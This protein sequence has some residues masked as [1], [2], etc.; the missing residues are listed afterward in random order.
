MDEALD[1][2]LCDVLERIEAG[3][4]VSTQWLRSRYPSSWRDLRGALALD[5]DLAP[6][7]VPVER[8]A[9]IRLGDWIGSGAMGV[10]F[11]GTP[12]D[13]SDA[14]RMPSRV[15]V[16]LLHP[17]FAAGPEF[18][19]R[20]AREIEIGRGVVHANLVRTLASGIEESGGR[21][22][23]YLVMEY[24]EGQTLRALLDE[25]GR[26]PETLCRRI[27]REIAEALAALHAAGAVHRDVK[28]EN[29]VVARSAAPGHGGVA[30]RS[31]ALPSPSPDARAGHVVVGA[32]EFVKLMDY[33]VAFVAEESRRSVEAP[34]FVGTVLYAA[35]EQFSR[36]GARIDGRTDLYALGVV[37]HE[38]ATG[39]H[40]FAAKDARTSLELRMEGPPA[41]SRDFP[42]VSPFFEAAIAR[43]MDPDADG[44]FASAREFADTLAEGE[45]SA[46]WRR[47]SVERGAARQGLRRVVRV[48]REASVAGREPEL[49]ALRGLFAQ[50]RG[51]SGASALLVGEAGVGK[52][53]L[54]DELAVRLAADGEDFH[55]LYGSYSPDAV[56]AGGGAFSAALCGHFGDAALEDALTPRL[57]AL[58][59]LVPAFAAMLRGSAARDAS[60]LSREAVPTLFLETLRSL[61]REK[62]T[63]LV[64][65]DLHFAGGDGLDLLRD[66]VRAI[67]GD[68]VLLVA[69]SRPEA[70]PSRLDELTTS[71]R[72]QRIDLARLGDD[73]VE[74]IVADALGGGVASAEIASE[75]A[76][77]CDGNPL[78]ALGVLQGLR[79]DGAVT[80]ELSGAWRFDR[81]RAG[82]G[83]PVGIREIVRGRLASLDAADRELLDV[84]AC[85][86]FEFD[87]T[88]VGEAI[89]AGPLAV[90]R[91]LAR[92]EMSTRL[93]RSSG[94]LFRFD[95]HLAQETIYAD[96]DTASRAR[97]HGS[98]A[99]AIERRGAESSADSAGDRAVALC[100]HWL[101]AG[102]AE[103]AGPLVI[104]AIDRLVERQEHGAAIALADEALAAGGALDV[105]G[106]IAV[107]LTKVMRLVF[108]GRAQHATAPADEAVALA[109]RQDDAALGAE[110][111]FVRAQVAKALNQHDDALRL[112]AEARES[113]PAEAGS[114]RARIELRLANT[115]CDVNREGEM[116]PHAQAALDWARRNGDTKTE[117]MACLALHIVAKEIGSGGSPSGWL[118]ACIDAAR[119]G[120][121]RS[122]ANQGLTYVARGLLRNGAFAEA[123]RVL[124]TCS[125]EARATGDRRVA[126]AVD[127]LIAQA[128]INLGN[129][130][131][132]R[133]HARR[134]LFSARE[135][136]DRRQESGV[137]FLVAGTADLLG[138]YAECLKAL[139][140][141]VRIS[142]EL[143]GGARIGLTLAYMGLLFSNVGAHA[144][145]VACIQEA[146]EVVRGR[147][148]AFEVSVCTAIGADVH[149][150]AG[151]F[152]A[153]EAMYREALAGRRS[154]WTLSDLGCA[155]GR[156]EALHR[157][158]RHDAAREV[159]SEIRDAA[160]TSA[161][162]HHRVI[163]PAMLA[164]MGEP[165]PPD[166]ETDCAAREHTARAGHRLEMRLWLWRA[167][168]TPAHLAEAHRL[169]QHLRRHAPVEYR[170]S[171]VVNHPLYRAV[172]EAWRR[173]GS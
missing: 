5:R 111:R 36:T 158:G 79:D 57:G 56:S 99:A 76:R 97:H 120:G 43:L 85:A 166:V 140:D 8:I 10:V 47:A 55:F 22:R 142:R 12:E 64:V 152:A 77:R 42:D 41:A 92:V 170:D 108:T 72:V 168:G 20:L 14:R 157:A 15:A 102:D 54:V 19:E 23:A 1:D 118:D 141:D 61:A 29:V 128:E 163:V 109:D 73:D 26:L 104:A 16:K 38:L 28:P 98:L 105:P 70:L 81:S 39:V 138:E 21:A 132:A 86:G 136:A 119:R 126:G 160:R 148:P 96:I 75:V 13:P 131:E 162:V 65:D 71:G 67:G 129:H 93:V 147:R 51:G 68:R 159:L 17:D 110:A 83:V 90:L 62:T 66:L 171:M 11:E 78:L 134:A 95:H 82:A 155:T 154:G 164:A 121:H 115:L 143:P 27:G 18:T 100:R 37:L 173:H 35:P 91:R 127:L 144:Q 149:S 4:S 7:A 3:G 40:P 80:R 25:D 165:L 117:A 2:A 125:E 123:R 44:R 87:P 49:A 58:A 135:I 124:D 53:R 156:A 139:E 31:P 151:D 161:K 130:E 146:M 32:D 101:R 137:L 172:D 84:A 48:S 33:G 60:P 63:V 116:A 153:A 9:G 106:R 94:A 167:T 145:A 114:L 133:A 50:A 34:A 74:R 6:A 88:L 89:G 30:E 45:A 69:S 24:A 122:Y 112:L 59:P 169:L 52:S 103:K 107:I 150:A 113:C 46:W